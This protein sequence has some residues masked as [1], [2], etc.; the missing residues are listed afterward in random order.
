ML[1]DLHDPA[2]FGYG[3]VVG[4]S[5]AVISASDV[6][7]TWVAGLYGELNGA[8]AYGYDAF[9]VTGGNTDTDTVYV[10]N[11][12]TQANTTSTFTLNSPWNGL[13]AINSGGG[14]P[15]VLFAGTGMFASAQSSSTNSLVTLGFKM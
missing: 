15:P 8:P 7:G 1:I 3:L 5:Q 4:S 13:I 2:Y 14:V 9:T 12:T 11:G 10:I 6:N